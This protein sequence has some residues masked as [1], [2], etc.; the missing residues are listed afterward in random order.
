MV[1]TNYNGDVVVENVLTN[2]TINP[3]TEEDKSKQP[4]PLIDVIEGEKAE[5]KCDEAKAKIAE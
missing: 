1:T 4:T 3:Q 2:E 5:V